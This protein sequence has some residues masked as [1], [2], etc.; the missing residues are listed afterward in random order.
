MTRT[1]AILRWQMENIP[2][3]GQ[4]FPCSVNGSIYLASWLDSLQNVTTTE[5][6]TTPTITTT[7]VNSQQ[8]DDRCTQN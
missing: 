5:T 7:S 2:R 1:A 4:L 3:K 8:P 6:G